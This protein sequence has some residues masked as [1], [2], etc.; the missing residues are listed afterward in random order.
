M[1]VTKPIIILRALDRSRTA[2]ETSPTLPPGRSY[3]RQIHITADGEQG[4]P[5]ELRGLESPALVSTASLLLRFYG[6]D[7]S[8]TAATQ[9]GNTRD[10]GSRRMSS[11]DG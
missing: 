7:P 8:A 5:N 1:M 11:I 4:W 2:A 6:A 3:M 10:G 9:V